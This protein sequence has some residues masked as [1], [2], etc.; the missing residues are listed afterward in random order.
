MGAVVDSLY[1]TDED[2]KKDENGMFKFLPYTKNEELIPKEGEILFTHIPIADFSF[3]NAYHATEK[4]AFKKDLFSSFSLVF[5]G[6]FHRHQS[7]KNI[8][9]VGSPVQ[10]NF[11]EEGQKKGFVVFDTGNLSWEFIHYQEAPTYKT[12][13]IRNFTNFNPR[14]KFVGVR[15]D[16]KIENLVKLKKIL[17]E[18]GALDI[19]PFFERKED[20][21]IEEMKGSHEN[22]TIPEII[23][24]YIKNVKQEGIDTN[25]LLNI[26]DT[27]LKEVQ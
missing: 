19:K 7:Q 4:H 13:D 16:E 25:K 8:V 1:S 24:E 23:V 22:R 2:L 5:T 27:V 17:Y 21:E 14:N 15:I 12:I 10:M 26:F 11:G 18:K 9:Y 3:D 20:V 6:H